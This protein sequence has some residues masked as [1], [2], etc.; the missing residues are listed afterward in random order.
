M[1]FLNLS[2]ILHVCMR[3]NILKALFD[4]KSV[5]S[6]TLYVH[7]I[8]ELDNI[9]APRDTSCMQ[10]ENTPNSETKMLLCFLIPCASLFAVFYYLYIS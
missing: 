3:A 2:Y 8:S 1:Q 5:L 9:D 7:T 10:Q 6:K 4:H